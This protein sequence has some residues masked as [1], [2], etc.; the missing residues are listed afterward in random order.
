MLLPR[1]RCR[2]KCTS[3]RPA[4]SRTVSFLST[5]KVEIEVMRRGFQYQHNYLSDSSITIS[6]N[7]VRGHATDSAAKTI[8]SRQRCYRSV[9]MNSVPVASS[10]KRPDQV[11]SQS[12]AT[13][14]R[15]CSHAKGADKCREYRAN[16]RSPAGRSGYCISRGKSDP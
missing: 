7:F 11:P 12:L 1:T 13:S 16:G 5:C 14:R 9:S 4:T 8:T 6:L 2:N 15:T 3:M 10:C